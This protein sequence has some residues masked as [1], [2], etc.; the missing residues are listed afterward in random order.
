MPGKRA[1]YTPGE[2][3]R[4]FTRA[5]RRMILH[6]LRQGASITH[7]CAYAGIEASTYHRWLRRADSGLPK[8][9]RYKDFATLARQAVGE[10]VMRDL[11]IIT[12]AAQAG[13]WEAASWRLTHR[14]PQDYGKTIKISGDDDHP[15][16]HMHSWSDQQLEAFILRAL[17]ETGLVEKAID[18]TVRDVTPRPVNRTQDL[19]PEAR[20]LTRGS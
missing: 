13:S 15:L 7:A 18:Q 2:R 12:A 4:K 8:D 14:Y 5:T 19:A 10:G 11:D 3:E 6:A 17:M 1:P 9:H 16:S 20:L